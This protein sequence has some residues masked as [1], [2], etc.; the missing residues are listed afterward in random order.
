MAGQFLPIIKAVAPYLAQVASAAIPAFTARKENAKLDP[1]ITQQIEELQAAASQNAHSVQVL[2]EKL[3]QAIENIEAT[4]QAADRQVAF[5]KVI[6]FVT[7]SL[8][9]VSLLSSLY[10]LMR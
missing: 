10:V 2:A 4:A 5:Y 1:V 7:V 9:L 6:I 8:S 3:Q